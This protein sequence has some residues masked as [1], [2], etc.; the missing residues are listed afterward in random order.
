MQDSEDSPQQRSAL[1]ARELTRLDIDIA[2]LSEMRFGEQGSLP[3]DGAGFTLCWSEKNKDEH[4][5]SCVGLWST[6]PFPENCWICHW[7]LRSHHDPKTPNPGKFPIVLSVYKSTLQAETGVKEAF[8][9]DLHNLLQQ[10]TPKT[11]SL[12]KETSTQEWYKTSN[13]G[14]ES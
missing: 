10:V 2:A 13:C 4:R 5:L 6:L 11:N 8:Y 9:R 3:D 12:S 7:S 1:V 14:K